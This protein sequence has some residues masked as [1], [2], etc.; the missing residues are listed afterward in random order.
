MRLFTALVFLLCLPYGAVA[1]NRR[2]KIASVPFQVVGSY[3][4]VEVNI[5]GSSTLNL[6]LDSGVSSTIITELNAEDSVSLN[7]SGKTDIKGLGT[8]EGIQALTSYNNTFRTG[9]MKTMNQTVYVLE[10]DL[11][12]FSNRVGLKINGI[13]GS[14]F[15][16]G[17]IVKI[18]YNTQRITFYENKSFEVPK[19]YTAIP[20]I[21]EGHKMFMNLP[22]TEADWSTRN[23]KMLLDTGAELTA[24]FRSNGKHPIEIPSRNIRGYIGQGLNGEIKG[25]MGRIYMMNIGGHILYNPVVHFPD[26]VTIMGALFQSEREGTIGSQILNRFNLIIDQRN[27]MLYIKPNYNFRKPFSYNIA[28][29]E[30]ILQNEYLQMPEVCMIREDSPAE[31]A[32]VR[33]G[34]KIL[35]INEVST[36]KT[37]INV[38][39]KYFEISSRNPLRIIILRE[40]RTMFLEVEMRSAL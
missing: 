29:I 25:Y 33:V 2:S 18:D 30:L 14:D 37:N 38:L 7:Y 24:W 32:G 10:Q 39:K 3:V 31:R 5:N 40:G 36:I 11:F 16:E 20:L 22:V 17:H 15:F 1:T 8:G 35:Q 28:G 6:I 26:S 19:K 4:V 27:K 23:A 34:D 21:L 12:N 9:R 13:L